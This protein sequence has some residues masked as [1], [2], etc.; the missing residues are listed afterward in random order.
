MCP[1]YEGTGMRGKAEPQVVSSHPDE[2]GTQVPTAEVMKNTSPSFEGTTRRS[3]GD[4]HQGPS[5]GTIR[6]HEEDVGSQLGLNHVCVILS[7]RR[8]TIT[9]V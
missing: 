8:D 4:E 9:S 1:S 7:R 2:E 5:L 3:V 6:V